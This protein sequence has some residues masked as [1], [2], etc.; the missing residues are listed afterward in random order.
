MY[1]FSSEGFNFD[2]K[3]A[4]QRF[5]KGWISCIFVV[6]TCPQDIDLSDG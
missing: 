3:V 5:F 4:S 6:S 1:F 2:K